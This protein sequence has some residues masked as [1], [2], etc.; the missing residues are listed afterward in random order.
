M[1]HLHPPLFLFF[2]EHNYWDAAERSHSKD[3]LQILRALLICLLISAPRSSHQMDTQ[4]S[5]NTSAGAS[6][7][8]LLASK[9][10]LRDEQTCP[11]ERATWDSGQFPLEA[12]MPRYSQKWSQL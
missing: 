5:V 7:S 3:V 11:A 4:E 12:V 10:V 9:P 1:W 8:L 2:N 6:F